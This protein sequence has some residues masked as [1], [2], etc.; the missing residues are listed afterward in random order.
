MDKTKK[1]KNQVKQPD[2]LRIKVDPVPIERKCLM[3]ALLES[4]CEHIS[5]KKTKLNTYIHVYNLAQ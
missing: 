1:K 4:K 5:F 3:P 2:S